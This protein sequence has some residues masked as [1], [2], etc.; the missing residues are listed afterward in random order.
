MV[1]LPLNSRGIVMT[2]FL[3][4]ETSVSP[5]SVGDTDDDNDG[6][7]DGDGD[8]FVITGCGGNVAADG[9]KELS[10]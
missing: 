5:F 4:S 7:N 8:S 9:A 3:L 1:S 2:P 10:F 6:D